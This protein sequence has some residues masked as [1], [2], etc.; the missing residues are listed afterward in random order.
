MCTKIYDH[1][2]YCSWDMVHDR[3]ADKQMDRKSDK[4]RWE[5]H[6]ESQKVFWNHNEIRRFTDIFK[7]TSKETMAR[8]IINSLDI[9][10]TIWG[11]FFLEKSAYQVFFFYLLFGCLRTN[12]GPLSRRQYHLPNPVLITIFDKFWPK[13]HQEPL[14]RLGPLAWPST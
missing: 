11:Y 8:N 12:I 13:S 9:N 5:S 4:L 2:M 14:T 7:G 10:C 6:L 1:M 3:A